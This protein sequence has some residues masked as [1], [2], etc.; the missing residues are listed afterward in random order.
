MVRANCAGIVLA[1]VLAT[2]G[3]DTDK[4]AGPSK[5]PEPLTPAPTF[6]FSS[7]DVVV[8]DTLYGS[9]PG[10]LVE[11][12]DGAQRGSSILTDES[13]RS[14]IPGTFAGTLSV[15]VTKDAFIPFEKRVTLQPK[16]NNAA[17]GTLEVRLEVPDPIELEPGAYWMTFAAERGCS[18]FP[19]NLPAAVT[20]ERWIGYATTTG[21]SVFVPGDPLGFGMPVKGRK[22]S[23]EF[24]FPVRATISPTST[25][26]IVGFVDGT[27]D[28]PTRTTLRVSF[29]G[30]ADYCQL[31]EGESRCSTC[32]TG[33]LIFT[34]K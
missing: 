1:A 34:K 30:R 4:G 8:I 7:L 17:I 2:A 31:V 14:N 21:Y 26:Q 27:S 20:L 32:R 18:D 24:D 3:C 22:I 6:S 12:L 11:L 28:E 10:V 15:R 25:L 33:Q 29:R 9:V 23:A 16:W 13:G 5:T 19:E